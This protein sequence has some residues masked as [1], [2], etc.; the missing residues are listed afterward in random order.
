METRAIHVNT[1]AA[2]EEVAVAPAQQ[3]LGYLTGAPLHGHPV[4][5]KLYHRNIRFSTWMV[6]YSNYHGIHT[7]DW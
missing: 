3:R 5:N 2:E 4:A 6:L 1:R 7:Y